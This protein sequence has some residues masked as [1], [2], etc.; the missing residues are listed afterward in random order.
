MAGYVKTGCRD[1]VIETF[2][3]V[4]K[5]PKKEAREMRY[6]EERRKQEEELRTGTTDGQLR[7]AV[8]AVR[9]CCGRPQ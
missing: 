3:G 2:Y 9:G 7:K 6:D 5:Q 8:R 4:V 1:R